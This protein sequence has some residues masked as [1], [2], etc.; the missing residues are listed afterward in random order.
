M[1]SMGSNHYKNIPGRGKGYDTWRRF[2][3]YFYQIDTLVSLEPKNILE[4]GIGNG[5]VSNQLKYYGF[6]VTTCDFDEHLKPDVVGDIR[7]LPFKNASF[8]AVACYE[9]L[10]HLPFEDFQNALKELHRV[11]KRHV[12]ISFPYITSNLFAYF[13]LFPRTNTRFF[14][15]RLYER[16]RTVHKF[17]GQHYWEMGKKGYGKALISEIIDKSG[18]HIRNEF[19]PFVHFHYFFVLEKKESV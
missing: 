14:F 5:L 4:I 10:E 3:S 11:S 17:D 13:R 8:D 16:S 1:L 19:T 18:F 12:V 7:N 2:I 9:V 6:D 15:F